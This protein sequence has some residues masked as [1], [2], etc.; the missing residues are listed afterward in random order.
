MKE[1]NKMKNTK[2][3]Y[4]EIVAQAFYGNRTCTEVAPESLDR[5]IL[6]YQDDRLPVSEPIDRSM[7]RIPG[8][9]NLVIIYNKYQEEE[10]VQLKEH[11]LKTEN[12]ELKPLAMIP[13]ENVFLYSR[14]IVC[15]MN[16]N[17]VLESLCDE[18]YDKFMR[19]L[20]R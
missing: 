9:D 19:Y 10:R 3:N 7:I 15:R 6:G 11:L 13:E 12:Y 17:G 5:F 18:D 14:C 2:K 20:A 8:T 1:D 4:L 16:E